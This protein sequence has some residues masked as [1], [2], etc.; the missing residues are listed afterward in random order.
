M[1]KNFENEEDLNIQE[2]S[3]VVIKK[4]PILTKEKVEIT[5]D[6]FIHKLIQTRE[7]LKLSQIQLNTKCK[8]PYKYTIRDIE[9]RRTP[10]T[11]MEIRTISLILN[12]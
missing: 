4:E 11:N 9:S 10:P 5:I 2:W 8:F 6:Q 12:I 3:P 1:P 7:E